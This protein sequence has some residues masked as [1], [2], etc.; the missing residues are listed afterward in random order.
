METNRVIVIVSHALVIPVF[1]NRWRRLSREDGYEVHLIIPAY[2]EQTWFGEKVTYAPDSIEDKDFHVH[3]I[4]T[5]NTT[6]WS[7]YLFRSINCKLNKIKPDVIYILHEEHTLIHQQIYLYARIFTRKSKI[8]FFSMNG[9][10]LKYMFA[11]GYLKK[12]VH[13]VLWKSVKRNTAAAL[14]HYPGCVRSLKQGNYGKPIYMQT[15]VGVD[16]RLF[17]PCREARD[18]IRLELG[19]EN[20]Y[21]I[22]YCGRLTAAKGVLDL[23]EAFKTFL[24]DYEDCVLLLVGNGDLTETIMKDVKN[25]GIEDKVII[26]GFI[27]QGD[28]PTYMNAMD[29]F[30][31]ASR[32][33]DKWIDTFPLVTVQAQSCGVPVI[34]SNS[35]SIPWQLSDTAAIFDEGNVASLLQRL[36]ELKANSQLRLDYSVKGMQRSRR[37]FC[38]EGMT[39]NFK[40][41]VDQILQNNFSFHSK[42][43]DYQQN[44]AF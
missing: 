40:S 6:N 3:P 9:R 18:T 39:E 41:I 29:Q 11:K 43:E 31:L 15:Q 17:R 37:L 7:T 26:T 1:Q 12:V 24:L 13:K 19:I 21:V 32:T 34:A 5:T 14:V 27:D 38:H 22:G 8:I 2:W 25:S 36:K 4:K 30:V 16:E 42:S 35:A 23:Y 44:K 33:T 28:V 10:G 20:K